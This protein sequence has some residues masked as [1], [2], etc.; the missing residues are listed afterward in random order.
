M[1]ASLAQAHGR[2]KQL[3]NTADVR[4]LFNLTTLQEFRLTHHR[5]A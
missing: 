2:T 5:N 3:A 1:I 4:L